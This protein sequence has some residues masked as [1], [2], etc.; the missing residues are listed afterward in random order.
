VAGNVLARGG[1]VVPWTKPRWNGDDHLDHYFFSVPGAM[2]FILGVDDS[3]AYQ[4]YKLG[5]WPPRNCRRGDR[6][7]SAYRAA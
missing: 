4:A 2:R 7:A 1:T 6:S 3:E 5:G